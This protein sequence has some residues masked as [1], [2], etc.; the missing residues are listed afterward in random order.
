MLFK[1]K[2]KANLLLWI[3]LSDNERNT[4]RFYS[5]FDWHDL[6]VKFSRKGAEPFHSFTREKKLIHRYKNWLN[7]PRRRT[8]QRFSQHVVRVEKTQWINF[9]YRWII[10]GCSTIPKKDLRKMAREFLK[11][12]NFCLQ[13]GFLSIEFKWCLDNRRKFMTKRTKLIN[14]DENIQDFHQPTYL[15]NIRFSFDFSF[16]T[17]NHLKYVIITYACMCLLMSA[18]VSVGGCHFLRLHSI[19]IK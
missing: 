1:R 17:W 13:L 9:S 15:R 6:W 10:L 3:S 16:T 18:K 2:L 5:R 8:W 12:N 7:F 14:W 4:K 19:H 11:E